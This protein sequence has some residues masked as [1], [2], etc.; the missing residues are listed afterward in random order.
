MGWGVILKNLIH[1]IKISLMAPLAQCIDWT[2]GVGKMVHDG[3][4][5]IN[6]DTK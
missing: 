4:W 1:Y 3:P 6:L 2:I 5:E